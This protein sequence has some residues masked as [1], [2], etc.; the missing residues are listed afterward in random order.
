[1]WENI[2]FE[3]ASGTI[4]VYQRPSKAS[5]LTLEVA[6][7][8]GEYQLAFLN[9]QQAGAVRDAISN[10]ISAQYAEQSKD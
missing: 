1:M 5:E 4:E 8:D 6:N 2:C 9:L 3:L 7:S 10:W